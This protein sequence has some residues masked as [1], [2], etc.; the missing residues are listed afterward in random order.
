MKSF[1]CLVAQNFKT[2]SFC[3]GVSFKMIDRALAAIC[4]QGLWACLIPPSNWETLSFIAS[5]LSVI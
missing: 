1:S 2:F 3:E 4:Y 5:H